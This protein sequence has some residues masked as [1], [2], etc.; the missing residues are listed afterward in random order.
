MLIAV[1]IAIAVG[2]AF[3]GKPRCAACE[4]SPQYYLSGSTY[5]YAGIFGEDYYCWDYQYV[6]T[7]YRPNPVLQ[8]NYYLP[9]RN[10]F[11]EEI[12]DR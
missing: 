4:Y 2:G 6:C 7:Y 5:V 3:A 12:P 8:P 1:A 10:G 9:C 11:F